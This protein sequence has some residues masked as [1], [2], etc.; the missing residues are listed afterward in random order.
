MCIHDLKIR[1]NLFIM[2]HYRKITKNKILFFI[3]FV[4]YLDCLYQYKNN[5]FPFFTLTSF[6]LKGEVK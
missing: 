2:Y 5:N 3:L 6:V 1:K 4:F